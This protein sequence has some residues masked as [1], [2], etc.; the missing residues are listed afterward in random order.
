MLSREAHD[1]SAP[2][3]SPRRASAPLRACAVI[4][5]GIVLTAL[6]G[7][8][9]DQGGFRPLYATSGG[10][11]FDERM[12]NVEITNVPGRVGQRIRNELVFERST[13]STAETA[14]QR[15]DITISE[16]VLTTLVDTTGA[17]SSQVYQL[18]A[19]YQLV[20]LKTKKKVFEGRSL[21]RGSFDRFAAIYSNIR[22]REDAENRVAKSVA[23]DIRTRVATYL[24][25][26][27]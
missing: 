20:D 21:G 18:E 19:R 9:P 10:K 6:G 8:S 22:A 2:G 27:N 1:L 15:L 14:D 25:R 3:L 16:T 12:A 11:T 5:V 26:P 24:S 23:E 13:G 4:A 7:C 17:S